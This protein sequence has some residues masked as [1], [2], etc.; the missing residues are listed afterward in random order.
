MQFV[1]NEVMEGGVAETGFSEAVQNMSLRM[2]AVNCVTD[3]TLV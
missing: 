3:W 2:P 1:Q